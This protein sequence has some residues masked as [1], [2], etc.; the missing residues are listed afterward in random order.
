VEVIKVI[1][2][3]II[4]AREESNHKASLYMEEEKIGTGATVLEEFKPIVTL[5]RFGVHDLEKRK[6]P[7]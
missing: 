3:Q 5:K 2:Q 1:L 4:A 6:D 7:S